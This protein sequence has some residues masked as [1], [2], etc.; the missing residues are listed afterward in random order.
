MAARYCL[1]TFCIHNAVTGAEETIQQGATRDTVAHWVVQ[2]TP[3]SF[4]STSPLTGSQ[5][6]PKLAAYLVAYPNT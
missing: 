5:T 6:N 1:Q 3:A 4:W 2:N